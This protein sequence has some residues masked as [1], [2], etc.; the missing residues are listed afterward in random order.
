MKNSILFVCLGNICRSSLAEGILR[1]LVR[2][3]GLEARV[4]ID[5]AGTGDWHIGNAPDPRAVEVARQNGIDISAQRARQFKAND[6]DRF[7][8]VLAMDRD[9]LKSISAQAVGR[10]AAPRLFLDYA[11]L[12]KQGDVPDPYFGGDEGFHDVYVLIETGCERVLERMR[13]DS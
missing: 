13:N 10:H 11:G 4:E 12:G 8:L 6:L 7:D 5:S 3:A 9:N 1:G 2:Q